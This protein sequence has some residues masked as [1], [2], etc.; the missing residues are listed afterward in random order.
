MHSLRKVIDNGVTS[1]QVVFVGT[2][3]D[4]PPL[5]V[6]ASFAAADDACAWVCYLNGGS[7]PTG[8]FPQEPFPTPPA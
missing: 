4:A 6:I 7:K 8:P 2:A 5:R 1:Y 3:F